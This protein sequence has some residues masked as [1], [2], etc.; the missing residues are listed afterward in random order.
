MTTAID[1]Q[2]NTGRVTDTGV[3]V[4]TTCWHCKGDGKNVRSIDLDT[5]ASIYNQY[6][7]TKIS[8]IK[9]VRAKWLFDLRSAKELVE[10]YDRYRDTLQGI[11]RDRTLAI[12]DAN[13]L[14][15]KELT[16]INY[17]NT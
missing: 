17:S 14:L 11:E 15:L 12:D 8:R 6:P 10:G 1:E 16:E 9:E 5:L 7:E 3:E 2:L 4:V 13:S